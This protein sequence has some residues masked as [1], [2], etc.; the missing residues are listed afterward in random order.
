MKHAIVYF[1]YELQKNPKSG[2][3][4]RPKRLVE[5]FTRYGEKENLKI[6]VISGQTK[7]RKERIRE[8]LGN[9]DVKDAVFC[10]MENS[11][12]PYWLTDKD[13]VPRGIGMDFSFWKKL[14]EN[15]VPIGCFYRDVYWQFDDMYVPPFGYKFLT[16]VMRNIY[17]RELST[18]HKVVD[19]MYLPSL[20]MNR[21]VKWEKEFDELPPGMEQVPALEHNTSSIPTAVYV[22]GITD[23]VGILTM[24]EAFSLLNE[25]GVNVKLEFICR[26]GEFKK[27]PE[28][29]KFQDEPWISIQHLSGD[30]LKE[31]YKSADLALI[32]REKNTYHDFAMPVKL[33]EYLSYSLPIVATNCDAH[34]RFLEDNQFGIVSTV[35]KQDFA[36]AV[37]QALKP[38]VHQELVRSIQEHAFEKNSWDARVQK[39]VHDL[40]AIRK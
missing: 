27:Y 37:H 40:T 17:R 12:M 14:K 6:I 39:V 25:G 4:V 26:E 15:H 38:E 10:Y 33:F 9:H 8:Y 34:A 20:E 36:E 31:V 24:L 11:T 13:H 22:G 18:Y 23:T 30:E 7:D 16:P 19:K 28:V 29:Q 35:D 2:S 3:G 5:A 1:P 21:F 32:P